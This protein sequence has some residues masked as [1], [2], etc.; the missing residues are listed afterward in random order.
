VSR[1]VVLPVFVQDSVVAL[2]GV[3]NKAAAYDDTDVMQL[4]LILE[5]V[6]K[7]VDRRRAGLALQVAREMMGW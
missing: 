1:F 5:S 3:A 4:N 7:L 2:V 6:W